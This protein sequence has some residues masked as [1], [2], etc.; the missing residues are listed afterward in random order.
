MAEAETV[1]N[2]DAPEL[3][4]EELQELADQEP[5]S[6]FL[7][8]TEMDALHIAELTQALAAERIDK[9]ALAWAQSVQTRAAEK[10]HLQKDLAEATTSRAKLVEGIEAKYGVALESCTFDPESGALTVIK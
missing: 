5:T 9:A 3:S 7:D 8:K 2:E 4:E 1:Q 6:I 10:A